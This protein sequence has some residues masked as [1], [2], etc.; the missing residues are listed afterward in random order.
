MECIPKVRRGED[1]FQNPAMAGFVAEP[2][3][4]RVVCGALTW[5]SAPSIATV[6]VRVFVVKNLGKSRANT[7]VLLPGFGLTRCPGHGRKTR[8]ETGVLCFSWTMVRSYFPSGHAP[9]GQ[10]GKWT[11][12][13]TFVGREPSDPERRWVPWR[14]GACSCT[15]KCERCRC[16][17][18]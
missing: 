15:V 18:E 1:G 8:I 17:E 6:R 2:R 12:R 5:C 11:R 9:A 3:D 10:G 4:F 16:R 13:I 7:V 14:R